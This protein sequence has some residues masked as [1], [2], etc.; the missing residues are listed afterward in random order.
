MKKQRALDLILAALYLGMAS[1]TK[2]FLSTW[3][4]GLAFAFL[5]LFFSKIKAKVL[6]YAMFGAFSSLTV[7][8]SYVRFFWNKPSLLSWLKLQKWTLNFYQIGYQKSFWYNPLSYMFVNKWLVDWQPQAIVLPYWSFLWPLAFLVFVG[9]FLRFSFLF[10]KKKAK[11]EDYLIVWPTAYLLF[12]FVNPYFWPRYI[13]PL[14][15]FFYYCL[16]KFGEIVYKKSIYA[17]NK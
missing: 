2:A 9:F 15:P 8:G 12:L 1:G 16:Y 6:K 13:I 4:I 17:K 3:V 7:W 14:L 11:S 10:L 5:L